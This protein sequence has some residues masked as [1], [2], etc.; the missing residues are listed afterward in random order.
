M[1]APAGIQGF[2]AVQSQ[3]AYMAGHIETGKAIATPI[4]YNNLAYTC[5][6][7]SGWGRVA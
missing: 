4:A 6:Q 3:I 5:V 7:V 2:A 1:A